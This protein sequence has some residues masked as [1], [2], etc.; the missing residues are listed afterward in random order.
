MKNEI[1]VR[2]YKNGIN[3]KSKKKKNIAKLPGCV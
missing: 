1:E 3:N 2:F